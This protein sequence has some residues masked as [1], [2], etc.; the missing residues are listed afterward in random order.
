ML[1]LSCIQGIGV[2]LCLNPEFLQK[3]KY[4]TKALEHKMSVFVRNHCSERSFLRQVQHI[5]M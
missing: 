3:D 5:I 4:L 2:I 1:N